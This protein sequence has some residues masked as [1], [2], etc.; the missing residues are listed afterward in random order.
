LALWT[1]LNSMPLWFICEPYSTGG[2]PPESFLQA[3]FIAEPNPGRYM[4]RYRSL[5]PSAPHRQAEVVAGHRQPRPTPFGLRRIRDLALAEPERRYEREVCDADD[6]TPTQGRVD[7][8]AKALAAGEKQ[9]LRLM[10]SKRCS[11]VTFRRFRYGTIQI[12]VG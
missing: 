6:V 12:S 3:S 2:G 7:S 8:F 4:Y 5:G 10:E 1:T 11:E 9:A